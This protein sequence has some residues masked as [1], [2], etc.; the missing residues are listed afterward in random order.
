MKLSFFISILVFSLVDASIAQIEQSRNDFFSQQIENIKLTYANLFPIKI[1]SERLRWDTTD[2]VF[3]RFFCRYDTTDTT[4]LSIKSKPTKRKIVK[5]M[6]ELNDFDYLQLREQFKKQY[7]DPFIKKDIL[8]QKKKKVKTMVC[9]SQPLF[10][11]NG[12]TIFFFLEL[13]G[14]DGF[15]SYNCSVYKKIRGKWIKDLVLENR[16]SLVY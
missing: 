6:N 1:S 7:S 13:R 12:N 11:N 15:S 3:T 9:F 2:Y 8:L 10:V 5:I 14:V 16:A 4:D